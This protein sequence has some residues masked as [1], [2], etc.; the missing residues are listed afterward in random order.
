MG[1]VQLVLARDGVKECGGGLT[2]VSIISA[3][4]GASNPFF[5]AFNL[6]VHPIRK[7]ELFR[8]SLGDPFNTIG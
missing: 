7:A 4:T 6:L 8:Q 1:T 5:S 3:P 2:C